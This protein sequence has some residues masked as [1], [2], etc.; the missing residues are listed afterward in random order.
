M[1]HPIP[2]PSAWAMLLIWFAGIGF[3][4]YRRKAGEIAG[5]TMFLDASFRFSWLDRIGR[6]RH[7]ISPWLK[8]A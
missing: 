8:N 5:S 6:F 4:T 1:S 7:G 3:A 2:E